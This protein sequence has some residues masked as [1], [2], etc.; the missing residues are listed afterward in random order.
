MINKENVEILKTDIEIIDG[1]RG[2]NYPKKEE[3][4]SEGYCLFL[5]TGNIINDKFS[6]SDC[7]FITEQKDNTL[8]KGKLKREDIILTTRG[9]VGSVAF[10]N[11]NIAYENIRINSGMVILRCH[12][13]Y[14]P[15]YLY[16]VLKSKNIKKQ[17]ELFSSGAAQPQLPIKSLVHI[18]LPRIEL[19]KQ[20]NISSILGTYDKIID[21]NHR[22]IEL[23]EKSAEL[24]YKEWF[25]RLKFPGYEHTEI[26]NGVP[27]GWEKGTIGDIIEL[28]YGKS[29]KADKRENGDILVYGSSGVIGTH[30]EAIS[31]GPGIILGRKGNAGSVFWS[32][33]DYYPIDTTYYISNEQTSPYLYYNFK[34]QDFQSSHGAVPGLNRDYAYSKTVLVPENNIFNKFNEIVYTTRKQIYNLEIIN[35]KLSYARDLLLPK[36]INGE[37]EV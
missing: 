11:D 21:N 18:K 7:A 8:R 10:Y 16:Q 31:K 19:S 36:L 37:I 15:E 14:L 9:T 27:E 22:R 17:F 13:E 3:F 6:L 12:N 24:L 23:L 29:L 35:N 1:D 32:Q 4:S 30:K 25:V 20:K 28:K 26:K 34:N 5:N 2:N 33:V